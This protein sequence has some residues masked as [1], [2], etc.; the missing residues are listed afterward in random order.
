MG[1]VESVLPSR[2]VLLSLRMALIENSIKLST[3]SLWYLAVKSLPAACRT[4]MILHYY[5]D[6]FLCDA[7][8]P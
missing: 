3:R 1:R 2:A 5:S 6:D 7:G 4:R 8:R